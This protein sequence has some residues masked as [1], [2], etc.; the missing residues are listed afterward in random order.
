MSLMD[1]IRG[2][3]GQY[4]TDAGVVPTRKQL[5]A[6]AKIAGDASEVARNFAAAAATAKGYA[7][8]DEDPEYRLIAEICEKKGMLEPEHAR[9]REDF[10]RQDALYFPEEITYPG[11]PDHWAPKPGTKNGRVHISLNNPHIYID[12]PAALQATAPVEN[13]IPASGS[14]EDRARAGR[15]ER[16]YFQWKE[17]TDFELL[18]HRA[19]VV[20]GAYG[21]TYGKV[22]WDSIE[23]VPQVTVIESPENLYVGWGDSDFRRMDWAI[24]CYG[25]SPQSAREVYGVEV[26]AIKVED[27]KY[28]PY[29]SRGDHR[30]PLNQTGQ[31]TL[32][33]PSGGRMPTAY[34]QLQ[35]EVYDYW[36][37]KYV[38]KGK[39]RRPQIWNAIYVGNALVEYKH[40]PEYDD[41]PY[42]PLPNTFIPG[43]PFGRPELWDL[44]QLIREKDER[45]SE[46][47][48]M[49]HS[50]VGG[51]MWQLVGT[52]APDTLSDNMM[53]KPNKVATPGPNAEIKTIQPFVPAFPVE[54][55]LK[56]LDYE[57]V[58][59]TGLNE[60][61]TGRAP[62]TA[63]GSSKAINALVANY[64]LR[65][66]MKRDL[67]YQWRKRIWKMAAK[68]W[69][70][71]DSDIRE[72]ID[73]Q[74]AIQVTP[75]DLTPRDALENAQRIIN[76]VQ[77]RLMSMAR[78]MDEIGVDDPE[79]EMDI[80]RDEQTDPALNAPAVQAQV[81]LAAT[82]RELGL[83]PNAPPPAGGVSAPTT[84]QTQNTARQV[85]RP[86]AGGESLNAPENQGN[87]PSES[88]P[89][90]AG[91]GGQATVQTLVQGG[92]GTGRILT[93]TPLGETE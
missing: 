75:P 66:A 31:S 60:L 87:P 3:P 78:A 38:G 84:E 90:N 65:I 9:L 4:T 56:R 82:M 40:H 17:D 39:K 43:Y 8:P 32:Q 92:E 46:A 68:V 93:Q 64:A 85:N 48:Q 5:S 2:V 63:L 1:R 6:I 53:P 20:K 72:L 30:D 62:L 74:Y 13:Y 80:I 51:Q 26:E 81:S 14:E 28:V 22:W 27:G 47:G 41:L 37:R 61:L 50:A 70:R 73:G 18:G 52:E 91:G 29:V 86:A 7:D 88:V 23:G 76:L 57:I 69:E 19:C 36:F 10:R 35:L 24:Y 59:V 34:E 58:G 83:D 42:V 89:T 15:A 12:I 67:Y 21:I 25:L 71:K 44:E 33:E 45:L 49:I 79:T 16:L 11:G 55:Y 77:N 54:E